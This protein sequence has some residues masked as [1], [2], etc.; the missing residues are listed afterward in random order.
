MKN[1]GWLFNNFLSKLLSFLIAFILWFFVVFE[2]MPE[3]TFILPLELRNQPRNTALVGNGEGFKVEVRLKGPPSIMTGLSAQQLDAVIDLNNLGSGDFNIPLTPD[4]ISVP[5]QVKVMG[6]SPSSV[7]IK[8][9]PIVSRMVKVEPVILGV[10]AEGYLLKEVRVFPEQVKV[11]GAKSVLEKLK[12]FST[13]S[14][15]IGGANKSLIT[16]VHIISPERNIRLAGGD[17]VE[18]RPI[19][20]EKEEDREFRSI[21]IIVIPPGMKATLKPDRVNVVL[22]GPKSKLT[23]IKIE[24]LMATVNPLDLPEGEKNIS[25]KLSLPKGISLVKVIPDQVE[26][27]EVAQ[28]EGDKLLRP[29]PGRQIL[30]LKKTQQIQIKREISVPERTE[31]EVTFVIP[32]KVKNYPENM[33]LIGKIE[34]RELKVRLKGPQKIMSTLSAKQFEVTID[35]SRFGPGKTSVPLTPEIISPPPQ[36]KVMGISPSSVTVILESFISRKVK[37]EPVILGVPAKGFLLKEVRV[38]PEQVKVVGTKN[39]LEKLK[40]ISTVPVDIGGAKKSYIVK[41]HIT[42]PKN[43]IRL[44]NNDPVEVRPVIVEQE[45]D[46]EFR[47]IPIITIPPGAKATIKPSKINVL[48]HGVKSK[49]SQIKP[50]DLIATINFNDL[51]E[52]EN[53]M[54]PKLSLPKGISLVKITP[55]KVEVSPA[56]QKKDDGILKSDSEPKPESEKQAVSPGTSPQSEVPDKIPP[57]EKQK[58]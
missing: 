42:P 5:T 9:E 17:Q 38:F 51:P 54:T 53:F 3:V 7:M 1:N 45:E 21:P 15:D 47:S 32:L 29:K 12:T 22:H 8:L 4:T 58:K 40:T 26:I 52:G 23:Q 30:P 24:E 11:F 14:V 57:Q 50:E 43:N 6:I 10:P 27:S 20:I 33:V 36:V 41:V 19:I 16:T 44:A 28:E 37:V 13:D 34:G 39:A 46:R 25:P 49:L 48:L 56:T 18:V 35:L 55:E 2:N 31:S